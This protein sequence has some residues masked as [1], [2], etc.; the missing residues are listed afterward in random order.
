MSSYS[1]RT[2][3][4]LLKNSCVFRTWALSPQCYRLPSHED[5]KLFPCTCFLPTWRVHVLSSL[6]SESAREGFQ[7]NC[8]RPWW[9]RV[10]LSACLPDAKH[11]QWLQAP[12]A[13]CVTTVGLKKTAS[14]C[15]FSFLIIGCCNPMVIFLPLACSVH[16]SSGRPQNKDG[17]R[18]ACDE[19]VKYG[20][21]CLAEEK[22][23]GLTPGC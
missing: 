12:L 9:I 14:C 5:L 10:W 17:E 21:T 13:T 6:V 3:S 8:G 4:L 22:N 7:M 11:W 19:Y 23:L 20:C 18:R 15:L 2:G 1:K 16:P